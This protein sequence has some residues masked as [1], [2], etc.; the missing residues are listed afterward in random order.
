MKRR[1]NL[2]EII[3]N[4]NR[5]DYFFNIEGELQKYFKPRNHLF[6]DYNFDISKTNKSILAIP[7][8]SN[9]IPLIWITNSKLEIESL[10]KTFYECLDNIKN[11]YQ[12]MYPNVLFKGEI[13]VRNIV[14]NEFKPKKEAAVLFS[15]GLDALATYLRYKN[16]NPFL[17]TEYGWHNEE[18]NESESWNAD[19]NNAINFGIENNLKNILI[20]SNYGTFLNYEQLDREFNKK[21]GDSWWHGLH[22]S[23]A[24][25]S[26]AIPVTYN[27]KVSCI[28]IASSF[29]Q[30]YKATCASD[31]SV[32]NEI[33]Y[34]SGRVFHD[35]YELTR[36]DK[37]KLVTDY[38]SNINKDINIRVCFKNDNN[39]CNCEKCLRTILGIVA[40]GKSPLDFGFNIQENLSEHV[41]LF[42]KKNVKFFTPSKIMAWDIVRKRMNENSD[43]IIQRDLLEWFLYYDFHAERKKSLL[44]YRITNFFPILERKLREK[45]FGVFQQNI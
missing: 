37:V 43:K 31:P 20:Q 42:L 18:L 28:Y 2:S 29:H 41:K 3:V 24:I 9:V 14:E 45:L 44:N 40:E 21:L 33:K 4:R 17:I 25:I 26:S 5:I 27:L 38:F 30:G 22:H 13:I 8:V 32:D 6:I 11:A 39:C 12:E 7:F 16:L 34:A 23:L 15:G 35:A 19:K 10:D 1:I 36:Q